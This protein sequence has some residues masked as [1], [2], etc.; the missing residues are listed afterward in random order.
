MKNLEDKTL[1]EIKKTLGDE[2][3]FKDFLETSKNHFS[4]TRFKAA[5]PGA[6]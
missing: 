3:V 6:L 5:V 1:G 2:Q 4:G